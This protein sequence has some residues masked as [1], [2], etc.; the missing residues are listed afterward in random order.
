MRVR[1]RIGLFILASKKN[2][3]LSARPGRWPLW[4]CATFSFNTYVYLVVF[5][6]GGRGVSLLPLTL[7]KCA[8]GRGEEKTRQER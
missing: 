8:V 1:N 2:K 6:G 7:C 5:W 3:G 4:R